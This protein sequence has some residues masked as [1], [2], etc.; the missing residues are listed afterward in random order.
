M[1]GCHL[2]TVP[3]VPFLLLGIAWR[4]VIWSL[5]LSYKVLL[6]ASGPTHFWLFLI[7]RI[8]TALWVRGQ[9]AGAPTRTQVTIHVRR[10]VHMGKVLVETDFRC[11]LGEPSLMGA[12]GDHIPSARGMFKE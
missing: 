10:H 12:Q 2:L 3:E 8:I 11:F 6:S 9:G 1:L 5:R 7:P 4:L